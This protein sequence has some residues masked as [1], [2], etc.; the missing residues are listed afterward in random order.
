M[1]IRDT[2]LQS[3]PLIVQRPV[4]ARSIYPLVFHSFVCTA[5]SLY[6]NLCSPAVYVFATR[7]GLDTTPRLLKFQIEEAS[8]VSDTVASE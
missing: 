3:E 6:I 8:G 2:S 1:Y 7:C 5:T 4:L